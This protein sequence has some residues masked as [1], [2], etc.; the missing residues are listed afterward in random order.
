M[1]YLDFVFYLF[2][3]CDRWMNIK[4]KVFLLSNNNFGFILFQNTIE[5]RLFGLI[6]DE[7]VPDKAKFGL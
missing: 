3:R 7:D 6:G 1:F 4:H 5:S 2:V